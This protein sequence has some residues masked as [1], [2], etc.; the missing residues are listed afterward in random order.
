MGYTYQD[1]GRL[2][3]LELKVLQ[4]GQIVRN[5]QQEEQQQRQSAGG[6]TTGQT[7]TQR[8]RSTAAYREHFAKTD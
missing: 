8:Q 1:I 3:P 7:P 4:L 5:E 2:T 6:G